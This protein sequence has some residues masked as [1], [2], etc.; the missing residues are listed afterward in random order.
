MTGLL[1]KKQ[2][3]TSRQR[4]IRYAER[5]AA[6]GVKKIYFKASASQREMI[7]QAVELSGASSREEFILQAIMK[8][9]GE[10]GLSLKAINEEL[11]LHGEK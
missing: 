11:Q 3:L 9:G 1:T 10:L 5:L 4:Q 8:F 7:R 2:P 6:F